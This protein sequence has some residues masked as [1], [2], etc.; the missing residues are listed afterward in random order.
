MFS[1][2]ASGRWRLLPVR[3]NGQKAAAIYQRMESG[4]YQPFGIHVLTLDR[5]LISQVNC[6]V[7]PSLLS[8][9]DLPIILESG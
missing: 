7:D 5:G 3:A 9:F 8:R 2:K 1:G 6:F 4:R